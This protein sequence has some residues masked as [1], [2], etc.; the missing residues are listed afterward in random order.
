MSKDDLKEIKQ[1][2][3]MYLRAFM[4]LAKKYVIETQKS[5]IQD[6]NGETYVADI[7][8]CALYVIAEECRQAEKELSEEK[9]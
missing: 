7:D 1:Q 5:T 6:L 4:N 9:K 8:I 3:D 2:R